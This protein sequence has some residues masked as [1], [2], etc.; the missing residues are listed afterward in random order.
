MFNTDVRY[1]CHSHIQH[2]LHSLTGQ[3][4][5]DFMKKIEKF[6]S[7]ATVIKVETTP[8]SEEGNNILTNK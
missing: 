5:A 8:K 6:L 2:I 3:K 4:S 7:G 1:Y